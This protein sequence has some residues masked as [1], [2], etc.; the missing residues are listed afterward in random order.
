MSRIGMPASASAT[1]AAVI[2]AHL[3][4]A[5]AANISISTRI[6]ERGNLS[7]KTTDS[8]ASAVTFEISRDLR[9]NPGLILSLVENGAML[10]RTSITALS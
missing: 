7:T 3:V 4:P 9:L 5:S 6:L 2:P 1:E 8:S 10:Y